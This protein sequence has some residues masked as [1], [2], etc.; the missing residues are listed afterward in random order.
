MKNLPDQLSDG[1]IKGVKHGLVLL[2]YPLPPSSSIT[3]AAEQNPDDR[4]QRNSTGK[5]WQ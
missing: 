4:L 3:D 1:P 5:R 2:L